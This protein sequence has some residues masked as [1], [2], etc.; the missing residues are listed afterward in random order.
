MTKLRQ[1]RSHITG[2][3]PWGSCYSDSIVCPQ[4]L[5]YFET[6][7]EV[8]TS[9]QKAN[10]PSMGETSR[11]EVDDDLQIKTGSWA[12]CQALNPRAFKLEA[13]GC[14]GRFRG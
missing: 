7:R 6:F 3:G 9:R 13:H 5:V 1:Y 12:R 4:I 2:T 10:A 8:E 11:R 14:R